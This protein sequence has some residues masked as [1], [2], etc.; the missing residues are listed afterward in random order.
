MWTVQ[1]FML[2]RLRSPC[3]S[4]LKVNM[5]DSFPSRRMAVNHSIPWYHGTASSSSLWIVGYGVSTFF[6]QKIGEFSMNWSGASLGC[7]PMRDCGFSY[8]YA[9]DMPLPRRIPRYALVRHEP[10]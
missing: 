9:R 7:A 2:S 4:P 1:Y 5:Y 8:S 6:I 3:F 10:A